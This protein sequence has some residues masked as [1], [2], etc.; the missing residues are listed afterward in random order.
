ML[1]DI[2]V[3]LTPLLKMDVASSRHVFD[4]ANCVIFLSVCI[5]FKDVLGI[6]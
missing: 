3:R 5:C 2:S 1:F 4:E 6:D